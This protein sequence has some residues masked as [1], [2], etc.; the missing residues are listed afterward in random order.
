MP[1]LRELEQIYERV[2]YDAG[3]KIPKTLKNKAEEDSRNQ[4][5]A[6]K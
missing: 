2:A 4:K 5:G 1:E 3:I 6:Q